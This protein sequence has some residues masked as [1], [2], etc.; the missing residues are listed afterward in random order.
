MSNVQQAHTRPVLD[1][2]CGGYRVRLMSPALVSDAWVRWLADPGI[3]RPRGARPVRASKEQIGQYVRR[4]HARQ[5]AVIGIFDGVT[6]RH[7][8]V[9]TLNFDRQHLLGL[10]DLLADTGIENYGRIAGDVMPCLLPRIAKRFRIEK[11]IAQIPETDVHALA[12]F[13]SS[14]WQL[15]AVLADE[16]PGL[17]AGSRLD[18]RQF[19]WFPEARQQPS[20]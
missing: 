7:A 12:Y 11:F 2:Q 13:A 14:D 1:M 5:R 4:M 9:L 15:E 3:M 19:A 16:I 10:V 20:G 17:D 6:H 18:V 8:G